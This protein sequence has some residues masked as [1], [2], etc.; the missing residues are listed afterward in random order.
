MIR[1]I[2]WVWMQQPGLSWAWETDVGAAVLPPG[3]MESSEAAEKWGSRR[4]R[5]RGCSC[6]PTCVR[7]IVSVIMGVQQEVVLRSLGA[8]FQRQIPGRLGG[9]VSG[10]A[11]HTMS[12]IGPND[13]E[14]VKQAAALFVQRGDAGPPGALQA[15]QPSQKLNTGRPGPRRQPA[16]VP[17]KVPGGPR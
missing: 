6:L 12:A 16:A 9:R 13:I 15:K 10:P 1:V 4:Q 11:G 17:Y 5:P 2:S 8:C 7:L 14:E 3:P